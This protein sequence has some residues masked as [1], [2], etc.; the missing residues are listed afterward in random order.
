MDCREVYRSTLGDTRVTRD[1][2]PQPGLG[3]G[4]EAVKC[5]L[6]QAPRAG[7]VTRKST[8]RNTVRQASGTCHGVG[9][10]ARVPGTLH[11][12]CVPRTRCAAGPPRPWRRWRSA[13]EVF[14][15]GAALCIAGDAVASLGST[16]QAPAAAP[17]PAGHHRVT[18]APVP[19]T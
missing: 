1:L 18:S 10:P 14:A 5:H 12:R 3:S 13:G 8:H 15:V 11:V 16:C 7:S 4:L 6:A 19:L 17:A 9:I 2:P